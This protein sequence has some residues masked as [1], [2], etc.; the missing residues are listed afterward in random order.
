[1][2]HE[3]NSRYEANI[4]IVA[5]HFL[6]YPKWD[7]NKSVKCSDITKYCERMFIQETGVSPGYTK[8]GSPILNKLRDAA[9]RACIG[10]NLV[11]DKKESGIG[12]YKLTLKGFELRKKI[13]NKEIADEDICEMI[14]NEY[15]KYLSERPSDKKRQEE[16]NMKKALMAETYLSELTSKQE[17]K[18]EDIVALNRKMS[19][20]FK[21]LS[22]TF[23][24][25][26]KELA[27]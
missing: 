17:V 21:S 4:C 10:L 2:T 23:T 15:Q 26:S 16:K 1:M 8:T 20:Y 12:N 7:N 14:R 6:S 22:E 19:L 18:N 13:I 27:T 24:K 3:E 5:K 11:F 25:I 9:R